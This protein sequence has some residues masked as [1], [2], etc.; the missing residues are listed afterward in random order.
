[1]PV[2]PPSFKSSPHPSIIVPIAPEINNRKLVL[3]INASHDLPGWLTK[4]SEVKKKLD[5]GLGYDTSFLA[6]RLP[7]ILAQAPIIR[8]STIKMCSLFGKK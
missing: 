6:A 2:S 4:Q 3:Q 5:Q 8:A 1:M 7:Q